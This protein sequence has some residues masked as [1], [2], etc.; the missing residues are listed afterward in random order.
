[1]PGARRWRVIL[2]WVALGCVSSSLVAAAKLSMD[3][4]ERLRQ[5]NATLSRWLDLSR[6]DAPFL[7]VDEEAQE[8]RL[9]HHRALLRVCPAAL[10]PRLTI[11]ASL[12]IQAHLRQWRPAGPYEEPDAGPF[13]WERYLADAATDASALLLTNETLIH[14]S[15]VW[16][17]PHDSV[18]LAAADLRALFDAL[19]DG[20][21]VITLPRGW[22]TGDAP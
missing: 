22:S 1:M 8:V 11:D 3:S 6:Q 12:V 15:S 13:D 20:T 18:R 21:P 5:I 2:L 10:T 14:A 4:E 9:Y 16:D 19:T 17:P 7:V